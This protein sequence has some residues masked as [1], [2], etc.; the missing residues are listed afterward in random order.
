MNKPDFTAS[1]PLVLA[2]DTS[3]KATSL[4]IARGAEVL[5]SISIAVD[6]KRSDRLWS[7]VQSLLAGLDLTIADV[8]AFA[9]CVGPGGF[10]GLRIGMAAA[11]ALR[12]P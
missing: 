12:L 4:A 3:S 1:E 9:V 10:T 2:L 8:D 6:E 7:E 11:K 5:K